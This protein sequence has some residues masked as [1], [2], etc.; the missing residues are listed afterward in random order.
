MCI[1]WPLSRDVMLQLKIEGALA[2]EGPLI[3][4]ELQWQQ[5]LWMEKVDDGARF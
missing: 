4:G 3:E 1:A 5:M 2:A